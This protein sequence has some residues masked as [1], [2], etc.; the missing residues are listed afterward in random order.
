M[1]EEVIKEEKVLKDTY[2]NVQALSFDYLNTT[3]ND[4]EMGGITAYNRVAPRFKVPEGFENVHAWSE[5]N[6]ELAN[7][8]TYAYTETQPCELCGHPIKHLHLIQNDDKEIY[9]WVGSECVNSFKGAGFSYKTIK[10]YRETVLHS[11]FE[12]WIK[13]ALIDKGWEAHKKSGWY[14]YP[15]HIY[16]FRKELQKYW[17]GELPVNSIS[18]RKIINRFKQADGY[19]V[20]IP[21]KAR[22]FF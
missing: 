10:E 22:E 9:M 13:I 19:G 17:S 14:Q 15:K 2:K 11:L 18:A 3:P 6:P 8:S 1:T 5:L 16:N 12:E 7:R 4:W 21:E 20:S